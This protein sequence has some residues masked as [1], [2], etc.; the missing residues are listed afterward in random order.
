MYGQ[1]AAGETLA[2]EWVEHQLAASGTYW[3]N[4]WRSTPPHPRPVW[5]IWSESTLHL[6]VGSPTINRHLEL[7]DRVTVHLP[8][9]T[10]VV[11]VDGVVALHTTDAE[12]I[13]TYDQKYD[14]VYDIDEYGPLTSVRP[15]SV[16]SWRAAGWA[17]RDGFSATG[18]WQ[19]G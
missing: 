17:G 6:S 10:D 19:F 11:I 15:S 1:P 8:S 5:G 7:G 4:P 12:L 3:V 14:W 9:D 18:S 16:L 2:W 13:R